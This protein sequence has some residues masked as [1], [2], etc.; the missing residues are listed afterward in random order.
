MTAQRVRGECR[1]VRAAGAADDA[2]HGKSIVAEIA[3]KWLG[4]ARDV[5][6]VASISEN[7]KNEAALVALSS[8]SCRR[9]GRPGEGEHACAHHRNSVWR[10]TGSCI[11]GPALLLRGRRAAWR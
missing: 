7:R 4:Y 6:V 10:G 9:D 8:S 11:G 2:R 3:Y 1:A 5:G